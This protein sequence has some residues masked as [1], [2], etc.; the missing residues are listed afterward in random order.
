MLRHP[1]G[2]CQPCSLCTTKRLRR[3]TAGG[4]LVWDERRGLGGWRTLPVGQMAPALVCPVEAM[5]LPA[6]ALEHAVLA[7]ALLS[8]VP[9]GQGV[10]PQ[11]L[12]AVK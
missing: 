9:A 1:R 2:T 3:S 4:L 5:Y 6:R 7:P 12:E 8:N 11:L 10:V